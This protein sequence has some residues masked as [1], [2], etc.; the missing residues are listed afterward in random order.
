MSFHAHSIFKNNINS[1]SEMSTFLFS[2]FQRKYREAYES[3]KHVKTDV[4]ETFEMNKAKEL[5]PFQNDKLYHEK[6][7]ENFG[8]VNLP[9]GNCVICTTIKSKAYCALISFSFVYLLNSNNKYKLNYF[10]LKIRPI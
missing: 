5:H 7:K 8:N 9:A 10:L 1:I 6:A 3:T 2:N 4:A